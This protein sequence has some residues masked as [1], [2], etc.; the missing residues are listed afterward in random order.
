MTIKAGKIEGVTLNVNED[1][2][3]LNVN[4]EKQGQVFIIA[5]DGTKIDEAAMSMLHSLQSDLHADIAVANG[6]DMQNYEVLDN[7]VFSFFVEIGEL[8][9]E[10]EFFK[11]WKKKKRNDREAQLEELVDCVHILL[12]I[13]DIRGYQKIMREAE[14]FAFWEDADYYDM[15]ILL[16]RLELGT[17][18]DVSM[19][20]SLVLGIGL[21]MG[22]TI[23]DIVNAYVK[24]NAK[25]V[26]RQETG[27]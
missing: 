15:F 26:E 2:L 8:A 19:A 16:K 24:K 22:F 4:G 12:G 17:F 9:N 20:F 27:Y 25:N 3:E 6:I 13:C 14:P 21:K 11:Y 7:L 10:V 23:D 1:K 18:Q 5:G